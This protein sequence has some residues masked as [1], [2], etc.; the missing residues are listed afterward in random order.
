M[1]ELD[2]RKLF[3]HLDWHWFDNHRDQFAHRVR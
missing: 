1:P 2:A 3:A